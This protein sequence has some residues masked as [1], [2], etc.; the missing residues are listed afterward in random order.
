MVPPPQPPLFPPLAFSVSVS[1]GIQPVDASA[2]VR[3]MKSQLQAKLGDTIDEDS[4]TQATAA[5]DT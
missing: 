5:C 4:G 3:E 2:K 1:V